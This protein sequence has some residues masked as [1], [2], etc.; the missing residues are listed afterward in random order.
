VRQDLRQAIRVLRRRPAVSA[1]VVGTLA[2]GIAATTIVFSLADAILWHPLP[3]RAQEQLVR[4]RAGVR[5]GSNVLSGPID[6]G[7]GS[8]FDGVHPFALDSAIVSIAGEPRAVTLSE[9]SSGLLETLRVSPAWGRTFASSEYVAGSNVVIVSAE[10]WRSRQVRGVAATDVSLT[11]DGKPW[12]IVGVMPEG[13][14][15][16]VSRVAMWRPF[17]PSQARTRVT[18][19]G[20]LKP[21]VSLEQAQV[22]AE[23]AVQ[24]PGSPLSE[25]RVAPFVAVAPT[26][27]TALRILL[28]AV[29]LLLVVAVANAATIVLAEAV[30]RDTEFAMRASLG[31]S[32]PRL[33]RQMLIET[34]LV[35][36]IAGGTGLLLASWTLDAL[37]GGVPYLMSFQ[38]LRPVG[39][40]WR[41]LAFAIVVSALAGVG[42]SWLSAARAM[43]A[44]AQAVL[45]G[46]SAGLRNHARIRSALTAAEIAVTLVLLTAAGLVGNSFLHLT[47]VDPGFDPKPLVALDVQLPAFRYASDEEMR[48][49][50]G[51][52]RTQAAA[53]PEAAGVTISHSMPPSLESHAVDAL[54]TDDGPVPFRAAAVSTAL[55]DEAFFS[56][57][58]IPF[59]SGRS[60]EASDRPDGV[61]VAI[62][63]RSFARQM[64]SD[65]EPLGHRFRESPKS[66][67]F[68]VVGVVEDVRNGSFDEG[69]GPIAYYT[70][71]SQ[72][73]P[74]WY[75]SLIVRARANPSQLVAALRA[76]VQRTMPDAPVTGVRIGD[77]LIAG[78]NARIRFA[79]MLM[80]AVAGVALIVALIGVYGTFWYTVSQRRR[81][82]GVRIAL[83]A[84]P[85][86]IR[87]LV[88]TASA[89]LIAAGLLVGGALSFF[90]TRALTSLLYGVSANDAPTYAV[91]I[92]V[93]TA[94]AFGATYLPARRAAGVDP[95]KA[96]RDQ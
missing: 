82:I 37:V 23:S 35:S 6:L 88:F 25:L 96:L 74:W 43:R 3:F 93:L 64:W 22:F 81:E 56:T 41:A 94:A 75:E 48:A 55:V 27:T 11:I 30:R 13:F 20:R 90:A 71:R 5:P 79:T 10:L 89:K 91:V 60:F 84:T 57:L 34:L 66:P 38:A 95:I 53:L 77:E 52:L 18:A 87:S 42:A 8:V 9:L 7:A 45:R 17:V 70:A 40:D 58:G 26:T 61:S 12:T 68:T 76:L 54:S 4:I 49:A 72:S 59:V 50:L 29:A 65:R 67:W 1:L 2:I 86:G 51:R 33:A 15:F 80:G 31:A 47:R 62:V 24:A 63:S 85:A 92:A 83:G 78:A 46:H 28:A 73:P 44:D 36:A 16:P 19:L 69:V 21:G 39:L 14:E 32:W